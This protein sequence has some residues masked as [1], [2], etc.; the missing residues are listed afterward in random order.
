MGWHVGP[1]GLEHEKAKDPCLALACRKLCAFGPFLPIYPLDLP[2]FLNAPFFW[3]RMSS[4]Q[5][6]P[7]AS[8]GAV[9]L[10]SSQRMIE[11]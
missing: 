6:L 1:L 10:L 3:S 2:L 4:A 8:F 5:R 7:L 11:R 9:V